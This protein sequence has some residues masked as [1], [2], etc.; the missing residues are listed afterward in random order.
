MKNIVISIFV[1][2]CLSNIAIGTNDSA[3]Q[4]KMD[5][6]ISSANMLRQS[7]NFSILEALPDDG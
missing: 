6:K 4:S 3:I 5:E 1:F 2:N 7:M